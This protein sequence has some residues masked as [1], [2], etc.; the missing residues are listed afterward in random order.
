MIFF[1]SRGDVAQTSVFILTPDFP[2][3]EGCEIIGG[4][5]DDAIAAAKGMGYDGVE[6]TM[7][8]SSMPMHFK[9][10]SSGTA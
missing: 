3:V 6:I 5:Y 2:A 8:T 9:L 4:S 7:G 1:L 10:P